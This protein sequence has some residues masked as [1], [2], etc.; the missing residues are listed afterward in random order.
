MI[1]L[2]LMDMRT[3]TMLFDFAVPKTSF[4]SIRFHIIEHLKTFKLNLNKPNAIQFS[5]KST[6]T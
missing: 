2:Q 1:R 3:N 6:I 4:E 5:H